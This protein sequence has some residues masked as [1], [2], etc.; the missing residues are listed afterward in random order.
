MP[1]NYNYSNKIKDMRRSMGLKQPEFAAL[2]GVS[3][4]TISRWEN[5]QNVPTD[6]AWTRIEDLASRAAVPSGTLNE[7]SVTGPQM[8]FG[9]DPESVAAVAE[10]VRLLSGHL[11]SPTFAT[12]ISLIDPLP[13][14]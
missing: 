7:G 4:I 6:L 13:H 3:P 14:Q 10:S 12:E 8:A 1:L 2:V 11:A 9:A 5:G